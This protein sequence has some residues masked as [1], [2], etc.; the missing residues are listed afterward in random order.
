[1]YISSNV[2]T[3][4]IVTGCTVVRT[5]T[6]FPSSIGITQVPSG[7]TYPRFMPCFPCK[8]T[9]F[10][11]GTFLSLNSGKIFCY[12]QKAGFLQKNKIQLCNSSTFVH[13][14]PSTRYL[15]RASSTHETAARAFKNP[16][17]LLLYPGCFSVGAIPPPPPR[18]LSYFGP[19]APGGVGGE[20]RGGIMGRD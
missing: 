3:C 16:A 1:M 18:H 5:C 20:G 15:K 14:F 12:M 13:G 9:Y 10:F 11:N 8:I 7:Y 17:G 19:T 2:R 4:C 6:V